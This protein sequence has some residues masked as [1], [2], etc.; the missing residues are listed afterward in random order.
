MY[1]VLTAVE[2]GINQITN[3]DFGADYKSQ[4]N[5]SW[6][7][8][9]YL[10]SFLFSLDGLIESA[11]DVVLA[12]TAIV[13]SKVNKFCQE[14]LGL[15]LDEMAITLQA[16]GLTFA[17]GETLYYA[18]QWAKTTAAVT[19][20]KAVVTATNIGV[21][22]AEQTASMVGIDSASIMASK[23]QGQGNYPGIDNWYDTT[24][25][26]GSEFYRGSPNGTDFWTTKSSVIKSNYN[27][28][29]LFDGLQVLPNKQYGYRK[30]V[31][32]YKSTVPIQGAYSKALA[33]PQIGNGGLPQEFLPN[34]QQLIDSGYLIP[35]ETIQLK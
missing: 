20:S 7:Q 27:A 12:P 15:G 34:S 16:N 18:T 25:P 3:V 6:Q 19:G 23:W 32:G 13:T 5:T 2:A 1:A 30:T 8:G 4:A 33:N 14:K 11:I 29:S 26:T 21:T 35:I 31:E 10:Q 17:A 9:K 24:F 28:E 22:V